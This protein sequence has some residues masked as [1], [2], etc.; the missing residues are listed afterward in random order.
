MGLVTIPF[1]N[2]VKTIICLLKLQITSKGIT[3]ALSSVPVSIR[4]SQ[5]SKV[6]I[7]I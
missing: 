5:P 3:D 7:F 2:G 4:I 6:E 1:E